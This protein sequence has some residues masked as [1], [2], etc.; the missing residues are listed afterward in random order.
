MA[1]AG[2]PL[3]GCTCMFAQLMLIAVVWV[4]KR[5]ACGDMAL[6]G[7]IGA[8]Q[9]TKLAQKGRGVVEKLTGRQVHYKH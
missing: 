9:C 4:D 5:L 7:N 6:K 2:A 8:Q 3:M 1:G